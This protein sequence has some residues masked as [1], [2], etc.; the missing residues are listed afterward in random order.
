MKSKKRK[1]KL[2]KIA[3]LAVGFLLV[4]KG[5]FAADLQLEQTYPKVPGIDKTVEEIIN[6]PQAEKGLGELITY[7]TRLVF[8]LVLGVCLVVLIVAGFLRMASAGNVGLAIKAQEMAKNGFLGLA[9]LAFAFLILLVINPQLVLFNWNLPKTAPTPANLT[10]AD[11]D[12]N[13]VVL[14]KLN[15]LLEAQ[16]A[17]A[18][19]GT[20]L[21]KAVNGVGDYDNN[22]QEIEQASQT[23]AQG[24]A[25]LAFKRSLKENKLFGFLFGA[26]QPLTALADSSGIAVDEIFKSELYLRQAELALNKVIKVIEGDI[27]GDT[28]PGK[29]DFGLLDIMRDCKCGDGKYHD[30]W[31][32]ET[33]ETEKDDGT[34]ETISGYYGECVGGLDIVGARQY[35]TDLGV[36]PAEATSQDICGL[37]CQDCGESRLSN[38]APSCDIRE[39]RVRVV[40]IID[41]TTNEV[42]N[43]RAWEAEPYRPT[44]PSQCQEGNEFWGYYKI[45]PLAGDATMFNPNIAYEIKDEDKK[46]VPL[47]V[48]DYLKVNVEPKRFIR[49]K[50]MELQSA[51][52]DL[53]GLKA[54]FVIEQVEPLGKVLVNN[55][56]AFLLRNAH[57]QGRMFENEFTPFSQNLPSAYSLVVETPEKFSNTAYSTIP[58]PI[59]TLNNKSFWEGLFDLFVK[60][61]MAFSFTFYDAGNFYLAMEGDVFDQAVLEH[62]QFVYRESSRASLFSVLTDLS[63]ERIEGFFQECL[64]SAFGK[65]NYQVSREQ[66]DAILHTAISNGSADR[67]IASLVANIPALADLASENVAEGYGDDLKDRVIAGC[68]GSCGGQN[69]KACGFEN[70][71]CVKNMSMSAFESCLK[72]TGD[73]CFAEFKECKKNNLSPDYISKTLLKTINSPIIDLL[74]NSGEF[75]DFLTG[76]LKDK[77]DEEFKNH[78]DTQTVKYYDAI[79][80]GA[81]TTSVSKMTKLDKV[82][83]TKLTDVPLL[84]T[85]LDFV[86][87]IDKAVACR[88][89]GCCRTINKNGDPIKNWSDCDITFEQLTTPCKKNNISGGC[90]GSG[91]CVGPGIPSGGGHDNG[92]YKGEMFKSSGTAGQCCVE[93]LRG[94]IAQYTKKYVSDL[95]TKYTSGAVSEKIQDYRES[96]PALFPEY[97]SIPDCYGL[98]HQGKVF[99]LEG[100]TFLA[101]Q[102]CETSPKPAEAFKGECVQLSP[103]D[104][105]AMELKGPDI[106][107]DLAE[108]E[109]GGQTVYQIICEHD[110]GRDPGYRKQ[111]CEGAGYCWSRDWQAGSIYEAED[112]GEKCGE[113]QWIGQ[114]V[115]TSG[116]VQGTLARAKNWALAGLINFGEQ[117]ISALVEM[118]LATAFEYANVFIEDEIVYPL[119]EYFE[120]AS[121]LYAKLKKVLNADIGDVLPAE[122][123]KTLNMSI[124]QM[125]QAFC[126]EYEAKVEQNIAAGRTEPE[127][128]IFDFSSKTK[129][130]MSWLKIKTADN[131]YKTLEVNPGGEF[132]SVKFVEFANNTCRLNKHL[133][134][135]LLEEFAASGETQEAIVKALNGNL[136]ELLQKVCWGEE[137]NQHCLGNYLAMT[138]AEILFEITGL[139]NINDLIK[140]T[141]KSMICGETTV[142]WQNKG[143]SQVNAI[144]KPKNVC[145]SIFEKKSLG[146]ITGVPQINDLIKTL[147]LPKIDKNKVPQENSDFY[148]GYC[149]VTKAACD[150]L[151]SIF[152]S[153]TLTTGDALK[154]L[155]TASCQYTNKKSKKEPN[156]INCSGKCLTDEGSMNVTPLKDASSQLECSNALEG[157]C[158]GCCVATKDTT[159][160]SLFRIMFRAKYGIES[161]NNVSADFN[162]EIQTYK[163]LYPALGVQLQIELKKTATLRGVSAGQWQDIIANPDNTVVVLKDIFNYVSNKT[164]NVL[165]DI[166]FGVVKPMEVNGPTITGKSYTT[167]FLSR[168]PSQLLFEDVCYMI[169]Q[170]FEN[171]PATKRWALSTVYQNER[172]GIG[173]DLPYSMES[174]RTV[175]LSK[176]IDKIINESGLIESATIPY[177]FCKVQNNTPA[178][179]LG[180]NEPLMTFVRPKEMQ[181]MFQIIEDYLNEPG[182]KPQWLTE[183]IYVLNNTSALNY[184][185]TK[186]QEVERSMHPDQTIFNFQFAITLS[187]ADKMAINLGNIPQSLTS[188]FT[189]R[190]LAAP[191]S[192]VFPL[193]ET[194]P[195]HP[196]NANFS[197]PDSMKNFGKEVGLLDGK[198]FIGLAP[199]FNTG[200]WQVNVY[201]FTIEQAQAITQIA[202]YLTTPLGVLA[203]EAMGVQGNTPIIALICQDPS[204]MIWVNSAEVSQCDV[205]L[206]LSGLNAL[207][208]FLTKMP[209]DLLPLIKTPVIPALNSTLG[210]SLIDLLAEKYD[211][212]KKPLIDTLGPKVGL[213]KA[214]Y[215]L[216]EAGTAITSALDKSAEKTEEFIKKASGVADTA[217]IEAPVGALSGVVDWVTAQIANLFGAK[218]ADMAT[219]QIMGS[220]VKQPAGTTSCKA[221]EVLK[222][223]VDEGTGIKIINCCTLGQPAVCEAKCRPVPTEGCK[224][225]EGETEDGGKC[226]YSLDRDDD[227]GGFEFILDPKPDGCAICR[228]KRAD[229]GG[230][231]N[232]NEFEAMSGDDNV[233]VCCQERS[234]VYKDCRVKDSACKS[235]EVPVGNPAD[236]CC[237]KASLECCSTVLECVNR[238][239][240]YSLDGLAD[241]FARGSLPLSSLLK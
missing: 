52:A 219:E 159:A 93:G 221:N 163:K 148:R 195:L 201:T 157:I 90:D 138:P 200:N 116:G 147:P 25:Y 10:N 80:N 8:Y 139:M 187:H 18:S 41:P 21:K 182:D 209:V 29:E 74:S 99:V 224:T 197:G 189:A 179:I 236:R 227:K 98:L 113:C 43:V 64:S 97:S 205:G 216:G 34:K 240:S 94:K 12:A 26:F 154:L 85:I 63:L 66:I 158:K 169:V 136:V 28:P 102:K 215:S 168:T 167:N 149:Y 170:D 75:K 15:P 233:L 65:A 59:T 122:V 184:L 62:N 173:Q 39:V 81:L 150:P 50:R 134:T 151:G 185:L 176:V 44:L 180:I 32:W 22:Y 203:K 27:A 196:L 131:T 16:V 96:H 35:W 171:D 241:S 166:P 178:E 191:A 142:K 112:R 228:L 91:H 124:E 48:C 110:A 223:V 199:Y 162:D 82:M 161:Q 186:A 225:N 144:D 38:G 101:P 234:S 153:P 146:D 13:K 207:A 160:L 125:L 31:H 181:I 14:Y 193:L 9:I 70:G 239:F 76:R 54:K 51:L 156:D 188:A 103:E 84:G 73:P 145:D 83:E 2:L 87:S 121:Q 123:V 177:I 79:L 222:E 72:E 1:Y 11:E 115:D 33:K 45:E 60:P 202:H 126:Q 208:G 57:P 127:E 231:C 217:L 129:V 49:A 109:Q 226:C 92:C 111:M 47:S 210:T 95:V 107:S 237:K 213:D 71:K 118:T 3:F 137:P 100:Q 37:Q 130:E 143:E 77:L 175:N 211:W 58:L 190:G 204:M 155:I 232:A 194:N 218:L 108:I 132:T 56:M 69:I 141:P 140:A 20:T 220:C 114:D 206:D 42:K 133:H 86:S 165:I 55:S 192:L 117:F 104:I 128:M 212:L 17:V 164:L 4:F 214:L 46:I 235:D 230:K 78:L 5:C 24:N 7:L 174:L 67:L 106:P 53:E 120:P 23:T 135:T 152:Q 88:I 172:A 183:M 89:N 40:S 238:K 68:V 36:E 198:Y 30:E 19:V 119:S 229:V 6:Q 105:N 61:T